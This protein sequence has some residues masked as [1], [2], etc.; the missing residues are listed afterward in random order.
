MIPIAVALALVLCGAQFELLRRVMKGREGW[1]RRSLLA[2][3][4]LLWLGA[5]GA[6]WVTLGYS[7]CIAFGVACGVVYPLGSMACV[8]ARIR[9]EKD[10]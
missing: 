5:M 8:M 7:A 10:R 4:A 3:K 9:K 6:V 2:G 1:R